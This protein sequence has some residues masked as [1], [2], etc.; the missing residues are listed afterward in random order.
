M[1]RIRS[2]VQKEPVALLWVVVGCIAMITA[3]IAIERLIPRY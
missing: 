3:M 2:L 1:S